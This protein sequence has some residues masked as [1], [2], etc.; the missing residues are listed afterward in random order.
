MKNTCRICHWQPP[1]NGVAVH[2]TYHSQNE[3]GCKRV[4][5]KILCWW[6]GW[7]VCG[8]DVIKLHYPFMGGWRGWEL[9]K[10]ICSYWMV[11]VAKMQN[12]SSLF[13]WSS[14]INNG[15]PVSYKFIQGQSYA[16]SG[17]VWWGTFVDLFHTGMSGNKFWSVGPEGCTHCRWFI[18]LS[19]IRK[20]NHK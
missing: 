7:G 16:N 1:S 5:I 20:T 19:Y 8:G 17:R 18:H 3:G 4:K 15:Y 14:G 9:Q 11:G 2:T 6:L 10:H 13:L 12:I